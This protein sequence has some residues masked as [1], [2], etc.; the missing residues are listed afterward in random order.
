MASIQLKVS[1]ETFFGQIYLQCLDG[2]PK[3]MFWPIAIMSFARYGSFEVYSYLSGWV[4][5]LVGWWL[6]Q[7]RI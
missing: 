2:G 1:V 7:M 6:D 3:I 5:G 4:V